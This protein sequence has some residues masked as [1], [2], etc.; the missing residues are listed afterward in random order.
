VPLAD[1]KAWL[2]L[3][4]AVLCL[5][6]NVG[7]AEAWA[8]GKEFLVILSDPRLP[9]LEGREGAAFSIYWGEVSADSDGPVE[10]CK[11][12][13]E[14]DA[15]ALA[16]QFPDLELRVEPAHHE[17]YVALGPGGAQDAAQWELA[18]ESLRAW[19]EDQQDIEERQLATHQDLGIRVTYL[20][21]RAERTTDCDF[22][23]PFV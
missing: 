14:A 2:A 5:K 20:M 17:A 15:D 11:P 7:P 22:V 16:A 3:E 6:R 18:S 23:V 13:P 9:W 19:A 4:P 21:N 10:W 8:F 1:V 12:I